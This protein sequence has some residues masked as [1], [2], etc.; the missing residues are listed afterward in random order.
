MLSSYNASKEPRYVANHDAVDGNAEER[1]KYAEDL[2]LPGVRS[3][4][5]E[6]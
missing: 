5:A 2:T 4:V 3:Q 1:I 6:T